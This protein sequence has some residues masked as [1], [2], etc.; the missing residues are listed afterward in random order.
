MI[1][2]AGGLFVY[3][4]ERDTELTFVSGNVIG[5]D[6]NGRGDRMLFWEANRLWVYWLTDNVRQPFDLAGSKRQIFYSDAPIQQAFLNTT[7]SHLF[8]STSD[9][10]QMVEVDDRAG[11][12]AYDLVNGSIGSFAFD[13]NTRTLYWVEGQGLL[14]ASVE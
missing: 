1:D 2:S 12:N 7:G 5:L 3:R 8:F 14:R 11:V 13:R 4:P 9:R 10:I 6:A